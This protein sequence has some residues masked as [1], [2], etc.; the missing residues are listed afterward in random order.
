MR[1]PSPD[2]RCLTL[3]SVPVRNNRGAHRAT[4]DMPHRHTKPARIKDGNPK[5]FQSFS[6]VMIRSLISRGADGMQ[7]GANRLA[8]IENS[9][10]SIK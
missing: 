9:K 8:Q 10:K 6:P 3:Y 7:G 4:L 5:A 2:Y 1:L